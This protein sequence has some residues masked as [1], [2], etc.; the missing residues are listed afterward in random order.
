VV[1]KTSYFAR[2]IFLS[3]AGTVL[4]AGTPWENSLKSY[5]F[6]LNSIY[7]KIISPPFANIPCHLQLN[8]NERSFPYL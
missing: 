8:L 3:I 5:S 1:T 7:E 2:A 6:P 4:K